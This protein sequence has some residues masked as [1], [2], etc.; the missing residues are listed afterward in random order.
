MKTK[1][2]TIIG[3]ILISIMITLMITQS[4]KSWNQCVNEHDVA[5]CRGVSE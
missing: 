1:I 4:I 2:I 5:Y 3:V